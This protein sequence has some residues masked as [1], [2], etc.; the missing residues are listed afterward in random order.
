[1]GT[2]AQIQVEGSKVFVY[3]HYDGYPEDVLPRLRDLVDRFEKIRGY[4]PEYLTAQIVNMLIEET[5]AWDDRYDMNEVGVGDVMHGDISYLY[6][7][8]KNWL[9][10]TKKMY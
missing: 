8:T 1:M 10:K 5:K 3:K 6:I 7:I 9:I 4:D 2:R